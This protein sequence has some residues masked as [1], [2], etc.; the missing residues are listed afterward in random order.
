MIAVFPTITPDARLTMVCERSNTPMTIF[1]VLVT[2]RTAAALL[3]AQRKNIH[4]S[5]SFILFR[6][7]I[8]WISSSVITNAK[9]NPA[10]GTITESDRFRIILKILPFHACGV[11][12]T[13]VE[14][15]CTF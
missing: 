10:M 11:V 1:H 8:S 7:T 6:S 5:T 9:I 12:P 15:S 3:K 13:C 14:I 4:V 2:I